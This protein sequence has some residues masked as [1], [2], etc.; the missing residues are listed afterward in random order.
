MVLLSPAT[1]LSLSVIAVF[2]ATVVMS[3]PRES[4]SGSNT[5]VTTMLLAG[6]E[7]T[8]EPTEKRR[9]LVSDPANTAI[10]RD[11]A[12]DLLS[13][14]SLVPPGANGHTYEPV[15]GDAIKAAT[16]DLYIENGM[17][18]NEAV[19]T[20]V[21]A[22][23]RRG[24]PEVNLSDDIPRDEVI[25]TDSAAAIAAHG[26]A[27]SFNAHFWTDPVYAIR[28]AERIGISLAALDPANTATYELRTA[29]FVSRLKLL[30]ERFRTAIA[31]I[32]PQ[33][34]KLVVYHDSWSY[35]GRRYGIPIVGAI[36]PVS[37]AE[38]SADEIRRM[39]DQIRSEGV[40][41]FFGSEV[42]PSDVL[43]A[44]SAETGARYF[45]DLSDEELPGEPGTTE[46]SYEGM[47]I[48]NVRLITT[49]LGGDLSTL[50]GLVP[51]GIA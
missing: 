36:Q 6:A 40:T 23:Y 3:N 47:M 10:V 19:S 7:S 25:S 18:L 4:N 39:I 44:I 45:S 5:S 48:Q 14:E 27:H 32:P 51:G 9:V 22:N 12:G 43:N 11:V 17:D 35:F 15:P 21:R 24:T 26:H 46:H 31:S 28:Y 29:A 41:A 20:F 13:V 37:F 8:L 33:N 16:A 42:F 30:D 2:A 50:D 38:P 1:Q 34:K 49:A